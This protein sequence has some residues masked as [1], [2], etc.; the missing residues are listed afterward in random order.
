MF[1]FRYIKGNKIGNTKIYKFKK[2]PFNTISPIT[3]LWKSVQ[4]N[5]LNNKRTLWLWVHPSSYQDVLNEL[6]MSKSI[7]KINNGNNHLIN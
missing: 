6:D 3:F 5:E 4:N 2:Y 1:Y 7:L